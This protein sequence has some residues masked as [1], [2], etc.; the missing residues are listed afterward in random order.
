MLVNTLAHIL[1]DSQYTGLCAVIPYQR[2]NRQE[3]LKI[4][5]SFYQIHQTVVELMSYQLF[6]VVFHSLQS[7]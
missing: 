2:L 5:R 3:Y 1:L 4:P 7:E 6:Q